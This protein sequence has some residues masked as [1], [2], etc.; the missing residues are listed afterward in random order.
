[1]RTLL[2]GHAAA[3]V[4]A[5]AVIATV[6]VFP[7]AADTCVKIVSHTDEYYYGGET[8]P[9]VDRT[10]EVWYGKDKV[11]YVTGTQR[12]VIDAAAGTF[13][14]VE[15]RDSSF[16]TAALPFDWSKLVG[17]ETLAF[18][19][20]YV[21]R[22]E[23]VETTETKTIGGWK[24]RRFDVATWIDV[25]DGRYDEREE[26][27]WVSSD[28]PIDWDLQRRTAR[29]ALKLANYDDALI[30]ALTKIDGL[31]VEVEARAYVRGFSVNS[32][33]RIVE[34]ADSPP[35]P[36]MYEVPPGFREKKELTLQDING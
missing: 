16:A 5:A 34:A 8:N 4:V 30:E 3:S 19:T 1:M 2:T 22:G 23:I 27:V 11:A 6:G 13:T 33:E 17:K 32:Y 28:V 26:K 29:D 9:A 10:T 7:C 25:E 21:R 20:R 35:P 14:F 31:S 15:T 36:G 12:F 24:C 18:L